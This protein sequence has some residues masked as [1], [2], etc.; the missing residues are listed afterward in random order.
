MSFYFSVSKD[1]G[2]ICVNLVIQIPLVENIWHVL[3][4]SSGLF[5][6]R[7]RQIIIPCHP[8]RVGYIDFYIVGS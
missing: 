7:L 4:G 1:I 6:E 3:S 8:D 2:E 5:N